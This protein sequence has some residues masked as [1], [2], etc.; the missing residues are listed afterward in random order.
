MTNDRSY[1]KCAGA[2]GSGADR[3]SNRCTF[4]K[5]VSSKPLVFAADAAPMGIEWRFGTRGTGWSA[6][7]KRMDRPLGKVIV[8]GEDGHWELTGAM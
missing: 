3:C 8:G 6:P 2:D 5:T 7:L 4:D 1:R